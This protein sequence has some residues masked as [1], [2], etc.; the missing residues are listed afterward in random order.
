MQTFG[1]RDPPH[2]TEPE[3]SLSENN[4][5][6]NMSTPSGP[7]VKI[8]RTTRGRRMT[9][10]AFA[11]LSEKDQARVLRNRRNALQTRARRQS[12]IATLKRNNALL[13]ASITLKEQQVGVFTYLVEERT[14]DSK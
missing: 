12:R 2:Q 4:Q 7:E 6:R 8:I 1:V 14:K 13:Q 3:T 5:R 10:E 9:E 11:A